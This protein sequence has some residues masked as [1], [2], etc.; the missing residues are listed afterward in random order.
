MRKLTLIL[1]LGFAALVAITTPSPAQIPDGCEASDSPCSCNYHLHDRYDQ[2]PSYEAHN[3]S[4]DGDLGGSSYSGGCAMN[5]DAVLPGMTRNNVSCLFGVCDVETNFTCGSA[6]VTATLRD[7]VY[8]YG[9]IAD[10]AGVRC[11]DT[12]GQLKVCECRRSSVYGG[13]IVD[14]T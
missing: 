12:S 8:A 14:C 11:V 6:R 7:C 5:A 2:G 4:T 10:S 1:G 3:C 13:S 9:I